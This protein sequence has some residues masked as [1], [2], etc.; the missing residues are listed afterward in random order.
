MIRS[1]EDQL[2]YLEMDKKALGNEYSHPRIDLHRRQCC[3][4]YWKYRN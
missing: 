3:G 4:C 2:R 1:K